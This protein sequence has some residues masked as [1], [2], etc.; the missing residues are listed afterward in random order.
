MAKAISK[1]RTLY[2]GSD[3]DEFFGLLVFMIQ[4]PLTSGSVKERMFK[5]DEKI[6]ETVCR[7]AVSFFQESIEKKKEAE[8]EKSVGDQADDEEDDDEGIELPKLLHQLFDWLLDHHGVEGSQV[9]SGK[10]TKFW[11]L[12]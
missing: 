11:N 2:D 7:F 1:L 9:R 6:L 10:L 4:L 12:F 3:P 5:H 8:A